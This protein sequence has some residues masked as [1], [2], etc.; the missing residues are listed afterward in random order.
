MHWLEQRSSVGRV[1]GCS[2]GVRSC[3]ESHCVLDVTSCLCGHPST[4][5]HDRAEDFYQGAGNLHVFLELY[6]HAVLGKSNLACSIRAS[7]LY[8]SVRRALVS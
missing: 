8:L 3:N 2:H 1:V 6:C 4:F 5:M 7:R